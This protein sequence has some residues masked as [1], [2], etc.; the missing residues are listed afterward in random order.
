MVDYWGW[1]P[2]LR[3]HDLVGQD[4]LQGKYDSRLEFATTV[5]GTCA[6]KKYL[7]AIPIAVTINY[8]T[9]NL[10]FLATHDWLGKDINRVVINYDSSFI[11]PPASCHGAGGA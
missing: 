4:K 3:D 5:G 6:Y 10:G 1:I 2:A 9:A 8:S 7:F 11:S